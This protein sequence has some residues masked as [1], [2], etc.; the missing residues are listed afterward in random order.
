[1]SDCHQCYEC[2]WVYLAAQGCLADGIA[3]G[4]TFEDLAEAW[5]CPDCGAPK[6]GFYPADT[7]SL[8]QA[9]N[10]FAGMSDPHQ[11]ASAKISAAGSASVIQGA[12]FGSLVEAGSSNKS[13]GNND[14]GPDESRSKSPDGFRI[15]E[16]IVC[17]WVY[18]EAKGWPQDGIA[19]GTR[20]EDI[21]EDWVCPECGVGKDDF[22]MQLVS[23][24]AQPEESAIAVL[25]DYEIDYSREPLVVIGTGLAAYQLVREWPTKI[26]SAYTIG[27]DQSR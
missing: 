3:A 2:G 15:W 25:S 7:D 12:A 10:Q 1:M 14:K 5:A 6:S 11:M 21:P 18:D 24:D 8:G 9:H 22:E 13:S 27:H 19:P 20:W 26:R 23:G 17:G 16:C 4:T